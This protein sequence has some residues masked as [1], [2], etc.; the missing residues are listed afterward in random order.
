MRVQRSCGCADWPTLALREVAQVVH[1][2]RAALP[3][4]LVLMD[5]CYDEFTEPIEPC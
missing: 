5:D 2:V 3:R 4:C 1:I